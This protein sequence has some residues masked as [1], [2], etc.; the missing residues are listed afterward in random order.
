M[1]P[2]CP[3]VSQAALSDCQPAVLEKEDALR[4]DDEREEE[5]E[6]NLEAAIEAPNVAVAESVLGSVDDAATD[7]VTSPSR[8]KPRPK[9]T[10]RLFDDEDEN[11]DEDGDGDVNGKDRYSQAS[12]EGWNT[13]GANDRVGSQG[14]RIG[15]ASTKLSLQIESDDEDEFGNGLG[16]LHGESEGGSAEFI[17]I[18]NFEVREQGIRSNVSSDEGEGNVKNELVMMAALG[19]G[20]GGIVYKA[21][22][23][24]TLRLVAVKTIPVYDPTKRS[25]MLKELKALYENMAPIGYRDKAP[26]LDTSTPAP[27]PFIVT[28]HDA[29]I[30]PEMANVAMVVEY[31]D[32]GSLQDIIDGGGCENED[33]LSQI[34]YRVLRGLQFIHE[35]H[36]IHRD[37]KPSN[38]L[39]NHRGEVKIS[40]FGIVRELESTQAMAS[41]FVGTLTYM[42]P[43]RISGLAYNANSDVWS[44]GLSLMSVALGTYPLA[45]AGGYWALLSSLNE[46]PVPRLPE[47][48]FS[49]IMIDFVAQCLTRDPHQRPSCEQLLQHPFVTQSQPLVDAQMIAGENVPPTDADSNLAELDDLVEALGRAEEQQQLGPDPPLEN[50][51][52]QLGVTLSL[53]EAK[54]A[55]L[56]SVGNSE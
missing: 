9:L 38:L 18:G 7:A 51:S 15:G 17:A 49:P 29:F 41:T 36:Q 25:Q 53:V 10:L 20:A 23:R 55:S 40:D 3:A 48:R 6:E 5:E 28:F 33:I 14:S 45:T 24:P 16:P 46:G 12:G 44:F 22:H 34:A 47:D 11:V 32:G 50:V 1:Q 4:G 56:L 21:V 8:Q 26:L 2:E 19:Q 52:R 35:R 42:S 39:I 54:F 43:E 31:M 13:E 30:N 27:C 37:I